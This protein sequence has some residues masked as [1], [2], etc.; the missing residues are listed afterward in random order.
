MNDPGTVQTEA[1]ARPSGAL[2][3]LTTRTFVY[4]LCQT[5]SWL[6]N[7]ILFRRRIEG[8][9][10]L[11]PEG[12]VLIASN[13]QSYLD[14]P[15]IAQACS[16]HLSFVARDSLARSAWLAYVMR[17]CGVVLIRRGVADHKA[18]RE[19]KAHLEQGDVVVVFPE[20]T[21][22]LDGCVQP[23][24]GGALL[25]ARTAGV[26]IVPVGI[27]GNFKAL[28]RGASLPRLCRVAMRFGEPIDS[29]RPDA[30]ELV[31]ASI[32]SMVGDGRF[33]SVPPIP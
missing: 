19:M 20:G 29:R 7:C 11:P 23:F 9:H 22:S 17:R 18:L 25:A 14:I 5:L 10:H 21:R 26:P 32:E 15:L 2:E 12:G 1:E 31:Q 28:P 33:D 27:R 6:A 4:R 3:I 13:H 8:R 30:L 24:R 16:R